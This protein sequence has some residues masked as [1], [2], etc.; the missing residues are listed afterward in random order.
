[1]SSAVG[2]KVDCLSMK[3][4]AENSVEESCNWESH[5]KFLSIKTH[6]FS[7]FMGGLPRK[8][9]FATIQSWSL[10]RKESRYWGTTFHSSTLSLF[11]W[12]SSALRPKQ[13]SQNFRTD[14]FKSS[15]LHL[16]MTSQ[17]SK[18]SI[19]LIALNIKLKTESKIFVVIPKNFITLSRTS[20]LENICLFRQMNSILYAVPMLDS[21]QGG[22]LYLATISWELQ[23]FWKQNILNVQN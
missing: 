18:R 14:F 1:M 22:Q 11:L 9:C 7:T 19:S 20:K 17:N 2:S 13:N 4:T 21:A 5:L 23:N 12:F 16:G 10:A 6:C 3:S 15:F 8:N